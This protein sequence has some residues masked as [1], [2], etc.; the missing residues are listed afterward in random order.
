MNFPGRKLVQSF[1]IAFFQH[2]NCKSN[3]A[4]Q[5]KYL[6]C[7]VLHQRSKPF[8][9]W[10]AF[11][12]ATHWFHWTLERWTTIYWV[13]LNFIFFFCI[14]T[15]E[16]M[17]H[18]GNLLKLY[19]YRKYYKSR[20]A[21]FSFYDPPLLFLFVICCLNSVLETV[22]LFIKLKPKYMKEICIF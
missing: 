16:F 10:K 15:N 7:K 22:V 8:H 3:G 13:H 5:N 12:K 19:I 6:L 18:L 9:S 4:H 11:C 21:I 14:Y 1:F 17:F 2:G 20:I